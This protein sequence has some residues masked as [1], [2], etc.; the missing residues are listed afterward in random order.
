MRL[1]TQLHPV[2]TWRITG[3]APPFA[4]LNLCGVYRD[5]NFNF[6]RFNVESKMAFKICELSSYRTQL[7]VSCSIFVDAQTYKANWC[8]RPQQRHQL[9]TSP[10]AINSSRHISVTVASD[11]TDLVFNPLNYLNISNTVIKIK[12]NVFTNTVTC[13]HI[14]LH[15]H[16]IVTLPTPT[17]F[18]SYRVIFREYNDT[19]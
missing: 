16:F 3:A 12:C 10:R 18:N 4:P 9:T 7:T 17:C 6:T 19:F 11:A 8:Q 1:T 15:H 14:A 13:N 5:T 2:P